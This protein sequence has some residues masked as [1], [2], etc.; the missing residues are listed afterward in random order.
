[1]LDVSYTSI[2][3]ISY[4]LSDSVIPRGASEDPLDIREEIIFDPILQKSICY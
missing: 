1:M 2:N 4:G 3:P